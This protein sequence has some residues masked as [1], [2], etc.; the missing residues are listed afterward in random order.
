[1][2]VAEYLAHSSEDV[3]FPTELDLLLFLTS[4]DAGLDDVEVALVLFGVFQN[5][6]HDGGLLPVVETPLHLDVLPIT[7]A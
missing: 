7:Q 2:R 1:M 6:L 3:L 5:D 4:R